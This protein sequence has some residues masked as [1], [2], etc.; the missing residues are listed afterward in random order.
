MKTL[1]RIREL[2]RASR[3]VARH[4]LARNALA[5][6]AAQG[7][8]YLI[9]LALVPFLARVLRPEAFGRLAFA[10]S[11][12]SLLAVVADFGFSFSATREIA[13]ER[14]C[15]GAQQA[16][17]AGVLGAKLLLAG[18]VAL[19][20]ALMLAFVPGFRAMAGFIWGACLLAVAQVASPA[21]FFQGVE[22]MGRQTG[23][24]VLGTG[25]GAGF[26]FVTV[27]RPEQAASVLFA[28]GAGALG[29]AGVNYLRMYHGIA[30]ESPRVRP[31][32]RMLRQSLA[33]FFLR[34]SIAL[35]TGANTFLLGLFVPAAAVADFAG[36][37]K[38]VRASMSV[39]TPVSQA[40]FP[41]MAYLMTRNRRRGLGVSRRLL[42]VF[43]AVGCLEAVVLVWAAPWAVKLLLGSGYEGAVVLLRWLAPLLPLIAI[44]N[45]LGFQIM[46]PLGMDRE[47]NLAVA[48]AAVVNIVL[49][50]VLVPRFGSVGMVWS[51]LVS[52]TVVTGG[53][54]ALLLLRRA[55]T[56]KP[57]VS[58]AAGD[59]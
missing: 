21:W 5:L 31:A 10:Q 46:L 43:A 45:V 16:I 28:M 34:A 14:D 3:G 29:A 32:L 9:P 6:Y 26:V 49:M 42:G 20:G 30:F 36:A 54:A 55:P 23:I 51:V 19:A 48:G 57:A 58:Q 11:L 59:E 37:D 50:L 24:D 53:Q 56:H 1:E 15:A 39:F 40:L 44:S 22:R 18:A 41:R 33:L 52:E 7:A 38:I 47:L 35:Y 17:V 13:R 2:L 12:A 4:P 27:R 8:R 25:L